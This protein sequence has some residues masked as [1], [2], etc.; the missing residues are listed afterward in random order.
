MM[1]DEEADGARNQHQG[2]S[3]DKKSRKRPYHSTRPRSGLKDQLKQAY[4]RAKKKKSS[5]Q[6]RQTRLNARGTQQAKKVRNAL[7]QPESDGVRCCCGPAL[8]KN[9]TNK[10]HA[11]KH[12]IANSRANGLHGSFESKKTM[13][14]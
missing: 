13:P 9:Q 11:K 3:N 10:K 6:H 14:N 2:T 8:T 5:V 7:K 4:E 1:V 12:A